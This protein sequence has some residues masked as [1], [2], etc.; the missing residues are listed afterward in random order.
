[1]TNI[2]QNQTLILVWSDNDFLYDIIAT[3]LKGLC[4]TVKRAGPE[5][6]DQGLLVTL[7]IVALSSSDTQPEVLPM[8]R[9]SLD[10]LSG[11]IPLLIISDQPFKANSATLIYHLDFPFNADELHYAVQALLKQLDPLIPG[12]NLL[13]Q[14][15]P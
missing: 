12:E 3:N 9:D 2:S 13:K 6:T 8:I 5:E 4:L 14:S 10:R 7:L 15:Y 1:M 11:R